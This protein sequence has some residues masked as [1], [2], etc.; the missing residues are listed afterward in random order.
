MTTHQNEFDV[1]DVA[2]AGS[3][4]G[5]DSEWATDN[6]ERDS[7]GASSDSD[8]EDSSYEYESS[9][10]A[11]SNSDSD[12]HMNGNYFEYAS[13]TE[14]APINAGRR[15][16]GK[17]EGDADDSISFWPDDIKN[18]EWPKDLH[19]DLALKL[20]V[21]AYT[22]F[23]QGGPSDGFKIG[24]GI[25]KGM[26]ET[27]SCWLEAE[28]EKP[29]V[30]VPSP[31]KEPS[32]VP[33]GGLQIP[34]NADIWSAIASW[35]IDSATLSELSKSCRS[36]Y[37][38]TAARIWST[39]SLDPILPTRTLN[40]ILVLLSN[41]RKPARHIRSLR[42][43][44]F[45]KNHSDQ[46]QEWD[47][48]KK[49]FQDLCNLED[50]FLVILSNLL[51]NLQKIEIARFGVYLHSLKR[52]INKHTF[53]KTIQ[54]SGPAVVSLGDPV[55]WLQDAARDIS[56]TRAEESDDGKSVDEITTTSR[57]PLETIDLSQLRHEYS[58]EFY[59]DLVD[60]DFPELKSLNLSFTT[61]GDAAV[62][63][64]FTKAMKVEKLAL[65]LHINDRGGPGSGVP[66]GDS[67]PQYGS[68]MTS[69]NRTMLP[70][71]DTLIL[72]CVDK[73][74]THFFDLL[75][76]F[77]NLRVLS[78]TVAFAAD[79]EHL[80]CSLLNQRIRPASL[81]TLELRGPVDSGFFQTILPVIGSTLRRLA[82][83]ELRGCAMKDQILFSVAAH[84]RDLETLL[85]DR[86]GDGQTVQGFVE[87]LGQ[88]RRVKI[89][90][91]DA[92]PGPAWEGGMR[93]MEW[94]RE[95]GKLYKEGWG[96][97][98]RSLRDLE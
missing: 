42:F 23:Q 11:D 46:P 20:K 66:S 73:G 54:T 57:N 86:R 67:Y 24:V 76:L 48:D 52:I 85:L 90:W 44:H 21:S 69:L 32:S 50:L 64:L 17:Y 62:R 81:H 31:T 84:C 19:S 35:I 33:I 34:M 13:D 5:N 78:L 12:S 16:Y 80:T 75:F 77:P 97:V 92:V 1:H 18:I 94:L 2:T 41:P 87:V 93:V 83:A 49:Q 40:I 95:G 59:K 6:S 29:K 91:C 9:S 88:C 58:Q 82:I 26:A 63:K 65:G 43:S 72:D 71:L 15:S 25:M 38:A 8:R 55:F 56:I 36:I 70:L 22:Y 89:G 10:D 3:D 96:R 4:D 30:A 27:L 79:E 51:P 74:T 28:K 37:G 7:I 98:A 60:W 39:I 53:V 14:L 45:D 47:G 68:L 61:L